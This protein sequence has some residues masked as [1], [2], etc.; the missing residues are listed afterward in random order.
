MIAEAVVGSIHAGEAGALHRVVD[1][2]V[3]LFL[4]GMMKFDTNDKSGHR[5]GK[6]AVAVVVRRSRYE[7][8]GLLAKKEWRIAG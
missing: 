4:V 1:G 8:T 6:D 3:G 2:A 7:R 5:E